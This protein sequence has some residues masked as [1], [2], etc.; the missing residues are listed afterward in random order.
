M[1][2]I[3]HSCEW[4]SPFIFDENQDGAGL[5]LPFW[6]IHANPVFGFKEVAMLVLSRRQSQTVCF[7]NLGIEVQI[8][9]VVGGTVRVGISAPPDILV[10]R[11][12]LPRP[13]DDFRC[14]ESTREAKLG[15]STETDLESVIKKAMS[16]FRHDI[17]NQMNVACLALQV[18]QRKIDAQQWNDVEPLV[19]RALNELHNVDKA[20]SDTPAVHETSA[21]CNPRIL[22]VE[23][24]P[25]EGMLL[26]DYLSSFQCDVTLVHDGGQALHYLRQHGQPDLVLLDMNMPNLDG[27]STIRMIREQSEFDALRIYAVS[28]MTPEEAGVIVGP[29]GADRWYTKPIRAQSLVEDIRATLCAQTAKSCIDD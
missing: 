6:R 22:I 15:T 4:I 26:A 2:W 5:A 14:S 12:E 11:G 3:K 17:R 21:I 9:K 13:A 23:D 29:E 28:G 24:N 16:R 18:L 27:P 10:L 19:V 1:D 8:L 25:N 7:P 20:L